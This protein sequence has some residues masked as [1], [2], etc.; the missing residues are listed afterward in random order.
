MSAHPSPPHGPATKGHHGGLA[1]PARKKVSRANSKRHRSGVGCRLQ[2]KHETSIQNIFFYPIFFF[3]RF[4]F[5]ML[6]LVFELVTHL[7]IKPVRTAWVKGGTNSTIRPALCIF[8]GARLPLKSNDYYYTFL[9]FASSAG[10][11]A[12]CTTP[13]PETVVVT[14]CHMSSNKNTLLL[15]IWLIVLLYHIPLHVCGN[16]LT[17]DI[18][19]NVRLQVREDYTF[20]LEGTN[21]TAHDSE[22]LARLHL[23]LHLAL[24]RSRVLPRPAVF[25]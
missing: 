24:Y 16:L 25:S 23:S 14:A 8:K 13:R 12:V 19:D 7:L 10:V 18:S 21:I 1:Q 22:K 11:G 4:V 3:R 6:A 2:R 17:L 5:D 15:L 20:K 9:N